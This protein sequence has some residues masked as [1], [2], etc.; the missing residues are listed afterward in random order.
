[1]IQRPAAALKL[2][3]S[4]FLRG[5][6]NGDGQ[7]NRRDAERALFAC[8]TCRS[9]ALVESESALVCSQCGAAWTIS[10]GIYDFRRSDD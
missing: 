2:A 4:I 1:L 10:D 9:Q 6:T 5:R 7:A 8:P 3:P